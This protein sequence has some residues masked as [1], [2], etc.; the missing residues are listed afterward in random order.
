MNQK[1]W[2]TVLRLREG[3]T[4]TPVKSEEDIE[5]ALRLYEMFSEYSGQ[6]DA[7]KRSLHRDRMHSPRYRFHILK[8]RN[9]NGNSSASGYYAA[10]L[11][12]PK[13]LG[14]ILLDQIFVDPEHRD[15]G[16]GTFLTTHFLSMVG[17]IYWEAGTSAKP[18]PRQIVVEHFREQATQDPISL[19]SI[20]R[21]LA[22][23]GFRNLPQRDA[24]AC[25]KTYL[26]L[27][28][29]ILTYQGLTF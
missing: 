24:T 20:R 18:K 8:P 15:N 25:P 17:G 4:V 2:D 16:L 13:Y 9:S 26:P 1:A 3:W 12:N 27:D 11:A 23:F 5:A 28:G 19:A 10:D 29:S 22:G 14:G 6:I 7:R 21:T